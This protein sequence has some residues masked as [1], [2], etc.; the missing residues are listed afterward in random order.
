MASVIS[1][2]RAGTHAASS[3]R[4]VPLLPTT[5][6]QPLGYEAKKHNDAYLAEKDR[7]YNLCTKQ[8]IDGFCDPAGQIDWR[9][10]VE[11]NSGN[12]PKT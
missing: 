8:F 10:L 3:S 11:F 1:K 6:G 9:K 12:L 5:E 7:A 4:E 2:L